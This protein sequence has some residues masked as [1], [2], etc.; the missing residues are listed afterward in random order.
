[1]AAG[2][3]RTNEQSIFGA[4]G[5]Q[6]KGRDDTIAVDE[7]LTEAIQVISWFHWLSSSRKPGVV[8]SSFLFYVEQE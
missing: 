4:D 7:Q 3:L 8:F 6:Y 5:K 1:M 2:T